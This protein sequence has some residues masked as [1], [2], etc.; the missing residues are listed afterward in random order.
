MCSGMGEWTVLLIYAG[1]LYRVRRVLG[2]TGV[3]RALFSVLEE[4]KLED[5]PF[6]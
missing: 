6:L 3:R 2:G 1:I 4:G 5:F